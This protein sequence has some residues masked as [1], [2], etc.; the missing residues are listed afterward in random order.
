MDYLLIDLLREWGPKAV[1]AACLLWVVFETRLLKK[2]IFNG[3]TTQVGE[4][5]DAVT[6]IS[7]MC[8]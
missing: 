6:K 3:L 2:A 1:L 7:T 5:H 8:S 4:I